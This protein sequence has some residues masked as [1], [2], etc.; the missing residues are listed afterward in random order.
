MAKKKKTTK[1]RKSTGRRRARV[2]AIGGGLPLE[3]I[4]AF[5]GGAIASQALNGISKNVAALQKNKKVLPIIKIGLGM[6]GLMKGTN[7]MLQDAAGGMVAEGALQLVREAAPNVF[8][9]LTGESAVGATLIDLDQVSGYVYSEDHQV[10]AV[11]D[12]SV[13]AI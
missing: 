7:Q 1:R 2:G 12:Y 13:A 5:A 8:Q 9:S 3:R 6:Y 4:A 11:E 10:G